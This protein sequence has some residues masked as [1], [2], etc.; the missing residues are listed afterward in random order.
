DLA[1]K[2]LQIPYGQPMFWGF[3][4]GFVLFTAIAAGIYPAFYLSSFQPVRV[5]KG[6]V[7]I[8]RMTALPRKVMVVAQFSVSIVLAI[9]TWI[10]YDQIQFAQ[11]RPIGYDR[12]SLITMTLNQTYRGKVDAV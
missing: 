3:A 5:L 2:N 8:G 9:S 4:I 6:K 10:V 1:D 12:A 7:S 11:D